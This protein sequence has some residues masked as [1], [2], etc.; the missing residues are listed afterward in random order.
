MNQC[1]YHLLNNLGRADLFVQTKTENHKVQYKQAHCRYEA[2]QG[3]FCAQA[4]LHF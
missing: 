1:V 4:V 3:L 2:P